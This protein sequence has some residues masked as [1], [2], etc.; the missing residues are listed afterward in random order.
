MKF[1]LQSNTE[2]VTDLMNSSKHGVFVQV[3]VIEAIRYYSEQV[4]KS[5]PILDS[6]ES[7]ISPKFWHAIAVDVN[8]KVSERY[9]Q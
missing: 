9:G 1:K 4:S 3:F 6:T 8:Q 7:V 2:F 5:K